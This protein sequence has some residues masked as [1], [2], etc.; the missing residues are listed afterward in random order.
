MDG[1]VTC[2]VPSSRHHLAAVPWSVGRGVS[3]VDSVPTIWSATRNVA[4][5]AA[6]P[7]RGWSSPIVWGDQVIVTSTVSPGGFKAPSTGI[8]GNDYVAELSK[9]GLSDDEVLARLRARD[10]ESTQRRSTCRSWSTASMSARA[11]RGGSNRRITARRSAAATG[12]T[13]MRRKRPRPTVNASTRCSANVGLF[14]YS[15]EGRLLWTHRIDPQPRYRLRHSG[16]AD[17]SRRPCLPARR[18]RGASYLA[19]LD[20]KTG[21]GSG[22]R[23]DR[24]Q[25]PFARGGPRRRLGEY[26]ADR[27]RRRS[28]VRRR[29][30][31]AS[32]ARNCGGSTGSHRR[33]RRPRRRRDALSRHRVAGR[34]ES[35]AVR[36][37]SLAP[38]AT[39]RS[40][41]GEYAPM[42]SS[43]GMLPRASGIHARRRSSI[44][45]RV[46]VVNDNGVLACSTRRPGRS[47]SGARRRRRARRSRRRRGRP[48]TRVLLSEDGDAFV[49]EPAISTKR[50]RRTAWTR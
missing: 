32:M 46:Y 25:R 40:P 33:A 36:G 38:P 23:E 22:K 8:F 21:A 13:R 4:W 7:G 17:R 41:K 30:V 45:G 11:D 18:Q 49:I 1:P 15:M 3:T 50:S 43:P 26:D 14:C 5:K 39:S 6:V 48:R 34:I 47:L 2:A 20:A 37:R 16:I 9:Q 35:S 44:R 27:N 29:S 19:A 42:S 10:I 12:R 28:A 31:T 24:G